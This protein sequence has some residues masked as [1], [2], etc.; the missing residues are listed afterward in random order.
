MFFFVYLIVQLK[1]NTSLTSLYML[2]S[3]FRDLQ[4][5]VEEYENIILNLTHSHNTELHRVRNLY[6]SALEEKAT[7]APVPL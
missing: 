1:L 5:K 6:Q 4:D 3:L 7:M 2:L